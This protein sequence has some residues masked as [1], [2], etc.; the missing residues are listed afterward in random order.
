[1]RTINLRDY[2]ELEL[3]RL[4]NI[5]LE[6]ATPLTDLLRQRAKGL[7]K[8]AMAEQARKVY[9]QPDPREK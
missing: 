5:G 9:S 1:M 8:Q 7:D 4:K 2:L 3:N 6:F